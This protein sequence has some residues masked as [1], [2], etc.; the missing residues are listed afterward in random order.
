MPAPPAPP[1]A[2]ASGFHRHLPNALTLVRVALATALVA[3]LALTPAPTPADR[4][5]PAFLA[6]MALFILAAAT[7]ALD[8]R[9]ARRWRV[10]SKFGRVMDPFADKVLVVGSFVLLAGPGFSAALP[11]GTHVQLSG[12]QPWMAVLVLARELLVT[13]IRALAESEG[14]DFS[15][16]W[17]GK[18]KMIVQSVAVPLILLL[19][20][21]ADPFPGSPARTAIV[22][23]AWTAVAV[24]V[25]SCASYAFR[26]ARVFRAASPGR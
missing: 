17:G 23:A 12:V 11:D 10:V 15:A 13:S 25:L 22:A 14:I 2:P 18:I 21:V 19:V 5:A 1:H 3:V 20:A 8:G 6:A 26:G 16:D 7:D 9:L 4:H 24:T